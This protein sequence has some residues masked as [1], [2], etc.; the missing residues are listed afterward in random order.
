MRESNEL[1][2]GREKA[3]AGSHPAGVLR[4]GCAIELTFSR[5]GLDQK[6]LHS[7]KENKRNGKP[8]SRVQRECLQN[9]K[10]F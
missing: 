10:H 5:Q 2:V 6:E 4:Y 9:H 3:A 1:E 8:R 7:Q